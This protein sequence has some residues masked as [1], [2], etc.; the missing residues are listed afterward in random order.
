MP[1]GQL[2]INGYDAFERWGVSLSSGALSSLITP[3]SAKAY[4]TNKS[5]LEHGSR[6]ITNNAKMDERQVSL[7]MHLS[8][9]NATTFFSRYES[10]CEELA[11]GNLV[12][13][14]SY[15]PDKYFHMVYQSCTQFAE[16]NRE[17]AK[18]VL[19]LVEPDPSFRTAQ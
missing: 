10:F 16:Y 2:K 18:F 9:P 7:Q 17:M 12:I 8:A 14:S 11:A 15:Y 1:K 4:V 19:K 5:R 3:A 6:V 13:W